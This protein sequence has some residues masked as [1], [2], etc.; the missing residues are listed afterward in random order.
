MENHTEFRNSITD[1]A[2][3]FTEI[4]GDPPTRLLSFCLKRLVCN[5]NRA[6]GSLIIL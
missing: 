2:S 5:K 6:M 1:G 3:T 4:Y